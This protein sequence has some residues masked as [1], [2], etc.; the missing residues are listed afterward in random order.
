MGN[1]EPH[2]QLVLA[3]I[4]RR[5][6]DVR[7]ER[8][9]E[10]SVEARR[11]RVGSRQPQIDVV[12]SEPASPLDHRPREGRGHSLVP[13][14]GGRPQGYEVDR[15]RAMGEPEPAGE[16]D[17][18]VTVDRNERRLLIPASALRSG[19]VPVGVVERARLGECRSVRVGSLRECP[20]PNVPELEPFVGAEPSNR[21]D[22][23]PVSARRCERRQR[24]SGHP[25]TARVHSLSTVAPET[26]YAR[27]GDV[28][29]AYQT[30]GD[31][32]LNLVVV[33]GFVSHVEVQWE[34]PASVRYL[35]Q[36]GSFARVVTFDRRGTGLSDPITVTEAP[37]LET[38]M[39]D[40]LVVM[41]AA[42]MERA[43]LLGVSEGGPMCM[44][45]AATYPERTVA[46]VLHGAMARSTYAS[47]HPWLPTADDFNEAG[48]ELLLPAWG[49]GVAG[50][51]SAP[52]RA[53]DPE[54]VAWY[55]R[56]ERSSI[57]PGMLASIAA[58]FYDTDVREVL[59][60]IQVP[61]L[62]LHRRGDRLVNVR[63]GRYLAEHIP[64]ARYVE[65]PGI[66]HTA[67]FEHPDEFL[68]PIEEFL[69]GSRR[70]VEPDRRLATVL[71]TDIVGSTERA[72]ALGDAD[73]HGLLVRHNEVA[74]LEVARYDGTAIKSTG[75]GLLATF[76][77]PAAAIRAAVALRDAV[78][79]LDLQLTIGLHCGEVEI[80]GDDIGGIAVHIAARVAALAQ[81][82]EILV[83]RTVKDLVAGSGF[84]FESHG[85]H[86]L[87][88]VPDQWEILA[89]S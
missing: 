17:P 81:A 33:P 40:L 76:T 45:F 78:A 48:A 13:R 84:T 88:G 20:Q 11:R 44:L 85:T 53:D 9:S 29:L 73:W 66:D 14:L 47:D 80:I 69:T 16:A 57:A 19:V 34:L 61:T 37:N 87:K 55:G 70:A 38:R 21:C 41:D 75:D 27:N 7:R 43:A 6:C 46:L 49:K 2:A 1:R 39:S 74:E 59:A 30:W 35:E 65:V 56:M 22:H 32:D 5:W 23:A 42:G 50:D 28:H 12:A 36:L 86:T 63:S 18:A 60:S 51:V 4:V 31:G 54:V 77:G 8:E 71:F 3:G 83:S 67:W 68:G 25:E 10:L 26:R 89:V 15:V 79:P 24:V 64:G 82:D 62:V 58:M 52:S 72:A